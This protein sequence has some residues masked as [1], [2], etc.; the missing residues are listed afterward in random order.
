MY[1]AYSLCYYN[2]LIRFVTWK[3]VCFL[4]TDSAFYATYSSAYRKRI[5]VYQH[6]SPVYC[7]IYTHYSQN[8]ETELFFSQEPHLE[9]DI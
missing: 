2:Y 5:F 7:P 3:T 1:E 8:L 6:G 4:Y 9:A